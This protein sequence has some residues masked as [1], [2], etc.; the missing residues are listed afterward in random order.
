MVLSFVIRW[1]NRNRTTK[2]LKR[3]QKR[4]VDDNLRQLVIIRQDRVLVNWS[5]CFFTSD[6][7]FFCTF[8]KQ[9][10]WSGDGKRNIL[11]DG[12]MKEGNFTLKLTL[13]TYQVSTE[14]RFQIWPP[15]LPEK[16]CIHLVVFIVW[17]HFV[18]VSSDLSRSPSYWAPALISVMLFRFSYLNEKLLIFRDMGEN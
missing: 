7:D 15:K 4:S 5:T 11:W 8:P 18:R 2:C 14:T 9:T 10:G 6:S 3:P 12:L 13:Q 1:C 17:V 16:C